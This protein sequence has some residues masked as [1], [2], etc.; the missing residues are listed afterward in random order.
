MSDDRN[1]VRRAHKE[2]DRLQVRVDAK[3][4]AVRKFIELY[5]G[6]LHPLNQNVSAI[7]E[8]LTELEE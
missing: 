3:I 5:K 1:E 8:I 6:T 4:D 7:N 2:I